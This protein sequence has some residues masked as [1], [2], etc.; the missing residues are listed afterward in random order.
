[1]RVALTRAL[2]KAS[3]ARTRKP[4][5]VARAEAKAAAETARKAKVAAAAVVAA[6]AAKPAP[7]PQAAPEPT[8][9]I[10]MAQAPPQPAVKFEVAKVRPVNVASVT[11][12]PPTPAPALPVAPA[13]PAASPFAQATMQPGIS[14]IIK[15]RVAR[16]PA[17]GQPLSPPAPADGLRQPSS[18]E[19]QM[20]GLARNIQPAEAAPPVAALVPDVVPAPLTQQAPAKPPVSQLAVSQLAVSQLAAA[21]AR[22]PSSLGAQLAELTQA[23]AMAKPSYRLAGPPPVA[24]AQV[25]QPAAATGN[26]FEIQIGAYASA[27]EADKRL[28]AVRAQIPSLNAYKPARH[29]VTIGDKIMYRARFAGFDQ[30]AALAACAEL[31]RQAI[32]CL[33]LKAD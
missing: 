14:D 33:A 30:A 29:T 12:M 24:E 32:N 17:V 5:L 11:A 21:A 23:P 2:A 27:T 8:P 3:T 28:A 31:N 15:T 22:P 7:L 18:F 10:E 6:A 19:T 4:V 13:A 16:A 1:M 9:V 20:A 26:G 25:P